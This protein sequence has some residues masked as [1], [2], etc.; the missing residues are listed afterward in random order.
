MV[1]S[2]DNGSNFLSH[3]RGMFHPAPFVAARS[4]LTLGCQHLAQ[5]HPP[6][7]GAT[8]PL[9]TNGMPPTCV[10]VQLCPRTTITR[11]PTPICWPTARH[12]GDGRP[13]VRLQGVQSKCL[14][15]LRRR[16]NYR[17]ASATLSGL[18]R[19]AFS[20][21]FSR[22]PLR[23]RLARGSRWPGSRS[24]NGNH[25]RG[26]RRLLNDCFLFFASM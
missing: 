10:S 2:D 4:V 22:F 5:H 19:L 17:S 20:A 18:S 11:S 23:S 9:T 21:G 6:L 24:G 15:L 25:G 14:F 12:S 7:T 26:W 16:N 13:G 3:D 1:L 8:I